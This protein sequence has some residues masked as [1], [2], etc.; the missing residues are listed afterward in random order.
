VVG[1]AVR[2]FLDQQDVLRDSD[3][4]KP[5]AEVEM[6]AEPPQPHSPLKMD[7][8]D[9]DE[10]MDEFFEEVEMKPTPTLTL[11]SP[12]ELDRTITDGM[13][14]EIKSVPMRQFRADE[15]EDEMEVELVEVNQDSPLGMY[16]D[17][18]DE[19]KLHVDTKPRLPL[20]APVPQYFIL[21]EGDDE[22]E[23]EPKITPAAVPE[24]VSPPGIY[25]KDDEEN[26]LK[27]DTMA[28]PKL[29]PV[30]K[31]PPQVELEP[32]PP[33]HSFSLQVG[34]GDQMEMNEV[35]LEVMP[36]VQL[37]PAKKKKKHKVAE[38]STQAGS[39]QTEMT[40][41]SHHRR[42]KL[43]R[44][45]NLPHDRAGSCPRATASRESRH[46]HHQGPL[47]QGP[48]HSFQ[49]RP[50][51]DRMLHESSRRGPFRPPSMVMAPGPQY[52]DPYYDYP[53]VPGPFPYGY[54]PH[55]QASSRPRQHPHNSR[56]HRNSGPPPIPMVVR[57]KSESARKR[58][59]RASQRAQKAF[60][61]GLNNVP[62]TE[63]VMNL[64]EMIQ[65]AR[66]E[67]MVTTSASSSSSSS[68]SESDEGS[69]SSSSSSSD[70][71]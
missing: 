68:S 10:D 67:A 30:V 40:T 34:I 27:V 26:A 39:G 65:E 44:A 12:L 45:E 71:E 60:R 36:V 47:S 3:N 52:Y 16:D 59:D 6:N 62:E 13:N 69:S 48:P 53:P 7:D 23:I 41:T 43:G 9:E 55:S 66:E 54:G 31:N 5:E 58:R 51:L 38:S 24:I 20:M 14:E 61:K 18:D 63:R 8:M 37:H 4:H 33:R 25:D 49:Q 35:N 64:R 15:E 19:N 21:V 22:G 70:S 2:A 42:P 29:L 50:W 46:P 57:V 11:H 32:V 28:V 17:D 1:K 56:R